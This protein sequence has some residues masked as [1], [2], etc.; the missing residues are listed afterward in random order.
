M[1]SAIKADMPVILDI[2]AETIVQM[3][4]EGN[5]QWDAQ[6]PVVNDFLADVE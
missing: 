2:V 3:H 5:T 1:R 4:C 6:Y